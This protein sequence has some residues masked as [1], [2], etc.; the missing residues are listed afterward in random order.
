MDWQRAAAEADRI[1][2]AWT[3]EGGPGGVILLFDADTIRAEAAGGLA[4]LDLNM[5][6]QPDS[7]VRYA[8]ISKHFF[9]ALLLRTGAVGLSDALGAHLP[10][11]HA[12]A[13]VTIGRALDMT[14]GLAD[15]MEVAAQLGI[16]GTTTMDREALLAFI[17]AVE[18]LNFVPGTEI[19]YSNTGYRLTQAALEAKGMDVAAELQARFFHPLGLGI[20]FPLDETDPV[21]NLAA[22]Y[23]RARRGWVKGRYGAHIS[24]SGGLAGS[25]R[26]LT[27]W[28]QALLTGRDPAAGLLAQLGALRHLNDGTPTGYGLGLARTAMGE[29]QLIGHG[30]SLPGYKNHFLLDPAASAGVVVVSNREDTDAHGLALRVMAALHGAELPDP[31]VGMLPDGLF[32]AA[33]APYWIETRG[34]GVTFLGAQT[35]LHRGADGWAASGSAHMP[36]R[37]RPASGGI[38]GEIGHRAYRFSPAPG[39]TTDSFSGIWAAPAHHATL[40]IADGRF[41]IGTGPTRSVDTLMPLSDTLALVT[42]GGAESPSSTRMLLAREG[43]ALR[44]ITNRARV[45]R[46]TRLG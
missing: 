43:N 37:L 26:D 23:W 9:A 3:E 17:S 16:S 6:F 41:A 21:A 13:A 46:L 32:V 34:G 29:R 4:S 42:R 7:A 24:A 15:T 20:S 18:G 11:A 1:A 36:V 8:S 14:G 10:L 38:E 2:Q 27:I 30:G 28:A 19:S 35:A 44:L 40:E 33:D 39:G 25:G 5:P 12:N 45:L 22:G 31:A